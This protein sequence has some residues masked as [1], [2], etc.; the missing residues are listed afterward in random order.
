M[1]PSLNENAV[2]VKV[3]SIWAVVKRKGLCVSQVPKASM[4]ARAGKAGESYSMNMDAH[5]YL[6]G[7][8]QDTFF[9][10]G[11]IALQLSRNRADV[12]PQRKQTGCLPLDL[13]LEG[14]SG[15]VATVYLDRHRRWD[16]HSLGVTHLRIR[17][18]LLTSGQPRF[19]NRC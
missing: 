3:G 6:R 15:A 7:S 14:N 1:T 12:N 16:D 11:A 4:L 18:S 10:L 2:Q 8:P 19:A 13:M 17:S 9:P 5:T